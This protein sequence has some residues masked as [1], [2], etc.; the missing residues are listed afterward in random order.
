M[1]QASG[2]EGEALDAS[3]TAAASIQAN[4]DQAAAEHKEYVVERADANIDAAKA[5]VEEAKAHLEGANKSL[6]VAKSERAALDE[7]Q[8]S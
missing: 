3:V 1:S 4:K 8:A 7:G 6:E 2:G 5:R